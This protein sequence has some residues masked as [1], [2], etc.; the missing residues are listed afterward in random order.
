M[1][2]HLQVL[3]QTIPFPKQLNNHKHIGSISVSLST[4]IVVNFNLKHLQIFR[5]R[6]KYIQAS[7]VILPFSFPKVR[8][9]CEMLKTLVE[10]STAIHD[11]MRQQLK[12]IQE[13]Y[14]STNESHNA[15]QLIV[16]H[17]ERKISDMQEQTEEGRRQ[18][19]NLAKEQTKLKEDQTEDRQ[20][21]NVL[22][23]RHDNLSE[24]QTKLKE[25]QTEDREDIN[26]LYKRHDN[27]SKEQTKLKEGQ[28]ED[29]KDINVLYKR[30]DNLS[31]E[32][33]KLKEG[34]IEDRKD[35]NNLYE[36]QAK[37]KIDVDEVK[38]ESKTRI[39][40]EQGKTFN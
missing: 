10:Q 24:E 15:L 38:G 30:H 27:L 18:I 23:K 9:M 39:P 8:H 17:I 3:P 7:V 35:I 5:Q 28:I 22:C 21:I 36:E 37:L 31:E 29:R 2:T 33:T 20:D 11:E 19:E 14:K 26:V 6:I 13:K 34:Q 1:T 12:D 16:G 25:G 32:Q 4:I 40:T